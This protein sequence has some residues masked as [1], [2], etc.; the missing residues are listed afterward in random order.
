[1][2]DTDAQNMAAWTTY[3]AH[4]LARAVKLPEL[5]GWDWDVPDAGPGIEVFGDVRGLRVLDLGSGLGRHAAYM[6]ALGAQVTAVDS[7]PTQHERAAARYPATRGLR[8]ECADAADHLRAAGPYDLVYSVSGLPFTDPRQL[9]A[10]LANGIRPGGRL[11]FSALHTNSDGRGPSSEVASRP[12][13]LRLPGTTEDHIV[14]MWVLSPQLWEDLLGEH[15]FILESVTA[16]D[17]PQPDNSVSYRLY[18]ARRPERVPS[19]PRSRSLPPPTAALGVGVIVQGADGVLLGRH[20]RGTWELA[21]GSVEP[22]ESFA[23]A[24]VRELYEEAGLLA[25]PGG[26][27]VLGTLLDQVG[28]IVPV[29]VP[30]LVTTWSGTPQQREEAVGSWRFWPLAALPQPLFVP[31]AQCLTAWNPSLPLDH[32]PAHVQP[33]ASRGW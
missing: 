32:P 23:E 17:S 18:A 25:D 3:G 27:R 7:S 29:T 8:L 16:I 2:S 33:Y 22:G 28:D 30:V 9:L 15:G 10:A 31:S 11:I 4:Q 13:V 24:A 1:M 5:D 21:G 19:R 14:H 6:A 12:E 20:R 26:A